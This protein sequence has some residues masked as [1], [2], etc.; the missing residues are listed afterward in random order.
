M[1]QSY[2]LK[3]NWQWNLKINRHCDTVE[4]VRKPFIVLALWNT[5]KYIKEYEEQRYILVT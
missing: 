1:D 3:I 4:Y 2:Q 5:R